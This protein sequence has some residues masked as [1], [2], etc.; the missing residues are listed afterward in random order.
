MIFWSISLGVSL[1]CFIAVV[2]RDLASDIKYLNL[3]LDFE[4]NNEKKHN[5]VG[6]VVAELRQ[7]GTKSWTIFE[8]IIKEGSKLRGNLWKLLI[9]LGS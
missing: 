2:A 5:C 9:L 4:I 7:V 8:W 6:G 3:C 1:N